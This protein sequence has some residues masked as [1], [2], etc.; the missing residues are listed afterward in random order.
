M[1]KNIIEEARLKKYFEITGKALNAAKKAINRKKRKDALIVI[2]MCQ[3][4]YD[5]ALFFYNK[6]DYV[7]AFAALNYSHGW[8]DAGSRLGLFDVKDSKLFVVK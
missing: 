8:I 6:G 3:R 4:Y 2:D 1:E 7:N 5:D